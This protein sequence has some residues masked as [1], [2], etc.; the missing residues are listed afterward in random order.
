MHILIR[1]TITDITT[2]DSAHR[3]Q[4]LQKPILFRFLDNVHCL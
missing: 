3:L 4:T 2:I 1:N